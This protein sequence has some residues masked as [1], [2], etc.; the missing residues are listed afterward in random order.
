MFFGLFYFHWSYYKKY[1]VRYL[2][3]KSSLVLITNYSIVNACNRVKD[4]KLTLSVFCL[5]YFH[6]S[7]YNKYFER[8][9]QIK[10]LLVV[11]T[12]NSIVNTR[13]QAKDSKLTTQ[14]FLVCFI[15]IHLVLL[16]QV[17]CK[18]AANQIIIS[19]YN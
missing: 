17:F 19:T 13:N 7:Y 4:T 2:Q 6:W 8:Y 3:I 10:W 15:F 12:D 16:Q 9:L 11:L 18:K 5:F 1:F 14:F